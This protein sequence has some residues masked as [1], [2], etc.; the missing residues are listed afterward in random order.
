MTMSARPP[1]FIGLPASV[2]TP[3]VAVDQWAVPSLECW[4]MSAASLA[5]AAQALRNRACRSSLFGQVMIANSLVGCPQRICGEMRVALRRH[6]L[7]VAE[8]S[9]DHRQG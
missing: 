5:L 3:L 1:R 9:A 6:A 8:Q 2:K 7:R 4:P